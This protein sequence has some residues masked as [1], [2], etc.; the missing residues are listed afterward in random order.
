MIVM[1]KKNLKNDHKKNVTILRTQKELKEFFEKLPDG[2][3]ASVNME[4]EKGDETEDG[5][6]E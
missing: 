6:T 3:I 1:E 2:V 5:R 4:S